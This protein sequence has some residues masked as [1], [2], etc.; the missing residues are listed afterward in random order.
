M[1]SN[2]AI[3]CVEKNCTNANKRELHQLPRICRVEGEFFGSKKVK[4]KQTNLPKRG[5]PESKETEENVGEERYENEYASKG[6][7]CINHQNVIQ[8]LEKTV[9]HELHREGFREAEFHHIPIQN[10]VV[11]RETSTPDFEMVHKSALGSYSPHYDVS[12]SAISL[13]PSNFLN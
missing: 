4:L 3:K 7:E 9:I 2:G 11:W 1:V 8:T 13:L 12:N 10:T 5:H 6:E